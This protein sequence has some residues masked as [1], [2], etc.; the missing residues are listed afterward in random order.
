MSS[1]SLY[2]FTP[3]STNITINETG[4]YRIYYTALTTSS[5]EITEVFIGGAPVPGSAQKSPGNNEVVG[6][7]D[8]QVATAPAILKIRNV[9]T[10]NIT[11]APATTIPGT[12]T[13]TVTASVAILKIM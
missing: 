4:F 9:D 8:A 3:P 1:A 13:N 6:L 10:Q 11:I 5:N 12:T 2:S 7:V